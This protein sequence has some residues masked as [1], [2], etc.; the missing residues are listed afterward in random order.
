MVIKW[1]HE[2]QINTKC[3]QCFFDIAETIHNKTAWY[4]K[5]FGIVPTFKGGIHFGK[6]VAGE[7]GTIKRDITFPV[8]F[9]IQRPG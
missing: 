1:L 5:N 2:K 9:S 6:I 4:I 3:V 7:I 8:M